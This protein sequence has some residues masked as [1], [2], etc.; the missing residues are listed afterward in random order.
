MWSFIEDGAGHAGVRRARCAVVTAAIAI[1]GG[2]AH[3]ESPP[4]N[5]TSAAAQALFYEARDLMKQGVYA[6]A[7][8]KLEHSLQLEYGIGTEFNLA[9]CDEKLGLL[10]SAWSAFLHAASAAKAHG[11]TEREELARSRARA[12]DRRV[13]RLVV[14]VPH[15]VV[16]LEI[17]RDG[18]PLDPAFWGKPLPVD[19]GLH[20]IDVST[21]GKRWWS[22]TVAVEEGAVVHVVVPPALGGAPTAD[23][24]AEGRAMT[25]P[26]ITPRP[27]A[28]PPAADGA[29]G[30][31]TLGWIIG[32]LGAAGIGVGASFGVASLGAAGRSRA[33][34]AGDRCD[35]RGVSL[36][37]DAIRSGDAATIATI[38]GAATLLGGLTLVLTA[39][40]SSGSAA[41][42]STLEAR[43]HLD[44]NGGG[45]VV[46]GVLE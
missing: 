32:G 18:S 17:A 29:I 7:C 21:F 15:A 35:A 16:R 44:A 36:R 5:D 8:P 41:S 42:S 39:P 45:L 14:D 9:D 23:D 4:A 37:D 12:L 40:R 11:Q 46:K 22:A 43:A 2:T 19:P 10:S 6:K 33:H 26:T 25:A 24:V 34:C 13:P 3:A 31:R 1:V 30:R 28:M 20:H 27:E 38:A